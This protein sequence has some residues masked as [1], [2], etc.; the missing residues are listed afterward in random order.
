MSCPGRE[1]RSQPSSV[2]Q[3]GCGRIRPPSLT[4]LLCGCGDVGGCGAAKERR[5]AG[6]RRL[7]SPG[8]GPGRRPRREVTV[9]TQAGAGPLGAGHCGR[10]TVF[11]GSRA[12]P[13]REWRAPR[14]NYVFIRGGVVPP[15]PTP[16]PALR[17]RGGLHKFPKGARACSG[18][19]WVAAAEWE[20]Y[21]FSWGWGCDAEFTIFLQDLALAR[22]AG[23]VVCGGSGGWGQLFRFTP[24][25]D[26][27]SGV[28]G[29]PSF[30]G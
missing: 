25:S 16:P 3:P 4:G 2:L 10:A 27:K 1:P 20:A 18:M 30:L 21:I 29:W 14:L 26:K 12:D 19:G 17:E 13:F 22:G 8:P 23:K 28:G 5:A 24:R 7:A 6:R 11:A 15:P 9:F